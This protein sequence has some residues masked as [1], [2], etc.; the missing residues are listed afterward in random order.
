[1]LFFEITVCFFVQLNI[2]SYDRRDLS[3]QR[4]CHPAQVFGVKKA[5]INP[6]AVMDRLLH[7]G[8]TAEEIKVATGNAQCYLAVHP[9]KLNSSYASVKGSTGTRDINGE[10][11]ATSYHSKFFG[12]VDYL[13]Y[14]N[15]LVPT[16]VL[17][18]LPVDILRRTG[19]LPCKKL[20]SDH[21][22][23]VTEFAFAETTDECNDYMSTSAA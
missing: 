9:L 22:A 21:L 3:G 17:D 18:T 4:S 11:L 19:G 20:G 5:I 7:N 23:L 6:F 13:W 12:T 16:R 1:M 14:S 8:W 2:K 10:P 15:S